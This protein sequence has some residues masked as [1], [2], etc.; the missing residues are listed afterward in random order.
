[1]KIRRIN[2]LK[3]NYRRDEWKIN[4]QNNIG[5]KFTVSVDKSL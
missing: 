1:M 4:F 2:N 5:A 3:K